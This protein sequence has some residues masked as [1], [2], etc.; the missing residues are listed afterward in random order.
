MPNNG[1]PAFNKN[2]WQLETIRWYAETNVIH[3]NPTHPDKIYR[4][5]GEL[6]AQ[7]VK[8]PGQ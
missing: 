4:Y 6:V 8:A 3:G 5:E 2:K 7:L 1:F